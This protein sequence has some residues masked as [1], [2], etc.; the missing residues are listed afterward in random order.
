[1]AI[2]L[3]TRFCGLTFRN[4]VIVPA[5]V[6]GRDGPTIREVSRSGVAALCTKTI[7]SQPAPDVLP[8]FIKVGAGMLNSVFGSDR[9]AE[10]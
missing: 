6:H 10:Y 8:C 7:V 9:P 2:E 3:A 4:P 1:M 5:G